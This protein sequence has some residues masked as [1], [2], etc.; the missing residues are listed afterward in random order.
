[1]YVPYKRFA[2]WLPAAL[3]SLS[4]GLAIAYQ[5]QT[6][7][8]AE[9][10]ASADVV[11]TDPAAPA[12]A[13][14][15][16]GLE[17]RLAE[18]GDDFPGWV[19]LA[20]SHLHMGAPVAAQP[21]IARA[22]S[23]ARGDADRLVQLASAIQGF[24]LETSASPDELLQEALRIAP[25]H[26]Q[27]AT[28]AAQPIARSSKSSGATKSLLDYQPPAMPSDSSRQSPPAPESPSLARKLD[29]RVSISD[30]LLTGVDRDHKVFIFAR[31]TTGQKVPL[32]VV[33]KQVSE[34][35]VTVTLDDSTTMVAGHNIS[36][37]TGDLTIVARVS[38][39]GDAVAAT[40]DLQGVMPHVK[41]DQTGFVDLVIDARV[42]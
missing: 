27:A 40:G 15:I 23:L 28:L 16:T 13:N 14:L 4:I 7:A 31:P 20:Q 35:P 37:Y 9:Q 5:L 26:Q 19:L 32:G 41:L 33:Q 38:R 17:A 8:I 42:D 21:A 39:S 30:H 3:I 36:G 10:S 6:L 12:V 34:L 11:T 1:M 25:D 22:R 18:N 24:E 2:R 29:V